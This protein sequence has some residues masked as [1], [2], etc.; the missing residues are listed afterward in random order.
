MKEKFTYIEFLM[1][2]LPGSFLVTVILL[3]LWSLSPDVLNPMKG[4]LS[5]SLVFIVMSF[6]FGNFIQTISHRGPEKRLKKE[7]WK[8][9]Y[10]SDI[11]FFRGNEVI[12]ESGRQDLLNACVQSGLMNEQELKLFD[13][14]NSFPKEALQKAKNAFDYIRIHLEKG[15]KV[16]RIQTA[17]GH[18]L[19]YRGLFVSCFL[20]AVIF[21]IPPIIFL[22]RH[23]YPSQLQDALGK[24][25]SILIGFIIPILEAA[26]CLYFWRVFRDRARGAGQGFAR[27]VS[28]IFCASVLLEDNRK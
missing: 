10:P 7:Y 12:D 2:V 26:I 8:K 27:E 16:G 9:H 23:S 15:D 24:N 17:E 1:Y 19:F 25:P 21:I 18:Y 22:L 6:I 4:N 5:S 11:M 3:C 14:P 28:R 20:A 13:T